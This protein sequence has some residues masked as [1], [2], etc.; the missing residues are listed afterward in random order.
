MTVFDDFFKISGSFTPDRNVIKNDDPCRLA[1]TTDPHYSCKSVMSDHFN[2]YD[3]DLIHGYLN[4]NLNEEGMAGVEKRLREDPHFYALLI[5]IQNRIPNQQTE[6]GVST[7]WLAGRLTCAS[8]T[9]W[10]QF[11]SG[12]VDKKRAD[13]LKFHLD[14]IECPFCRANVADLQN[15]NQGGAGSIIAKKSAT[16]AGWRQKKQ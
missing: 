10:T 12:L 9:E 2:H 8:R 13:Y 11:F 5:R 14:V 7:A 3:E 6:H 4:E 1:E 16:A 15:R